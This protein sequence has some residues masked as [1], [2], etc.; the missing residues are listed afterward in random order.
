MPTAS[1]TDYQAQTLS[2]QVIVDVSNLFKF[3]VTPSTSAAGQSVT[4]TIT[5]QAPAGPGGTP[6]QLTSDNPTLVPVPPSVTVSNGTTGTSLQIPIQN[7]AVLQPTVVNLTASRGTQSITQQLTVEEATITLTTDLSSILGGNKLN[8]TVTLSAPVSAD[9]AVTINFSPN[10]ILSVPVPVVIPAGSNTATFEIDSAGV[11]SD[12]TVTLTA[13][14]GSVTSA[15]TTVEVTAPTLVKIAFY[16]PFI[17]GGKI[18]HGIITL[19]GPAPAGGLD[20][21]LAAVPGLLLLPTHIVVPAGATSAP[22]L[23]FAV[24]RVSRKIA[25]TV[26]ATCNDTSV[27]TTILISR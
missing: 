11:T 23:G 8:G 15:P 6:V 21:Q 22:I 12:Q 18:A 2:A 5:L 3:T 25:V 10:G 1:G 27:Y 19:D 16:P 24:P 17:R 13:T 7:V 4:G 20:I 26:T 9:T 14:A